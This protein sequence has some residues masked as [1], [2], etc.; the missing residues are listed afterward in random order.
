[1]RPLNKLLFGVLFAMGL[2]LAAAGRAQADEVVF[3]NFGP[4]MTFNTASGGIISGSNVFGGRVVAHSFI[5]SMDFTFS[6]A[7]LAMGIISGPN[8]LQ[9]VLMTSSGGFP[10]SIVESITLMNAVAPI[11]SPGI[12]TATSTL[13]PPLNSATQYWLVAFAPEDD[14][15]LAWMFA[16]NDF[17]G[18][19]RANST[20]S[21][22]GPWPEFG[23]SDHAF[24][25][26]GTPVPEPATMLLVGPVLLIMALK[27]RRS[28]A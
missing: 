7:Q 4:G 8:V 11:S 13:R 6:N 22:T 26:V 9:V 23:T 18:L 28:K 24:Q 21:L 10:G 27:R 16:L 15:S 1:M 19:F 3:S 25:I 5:P 2:F 14:S 20:H 17:S 12:V